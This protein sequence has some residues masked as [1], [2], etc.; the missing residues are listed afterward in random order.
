MIRLVP[1]LLVVILACESGGD[2][3]ASRAAD[4]ASLKGFVM[5]LNAA[6]RDA[7]A[8]HAVNLDS[9]FSVSFD[10]DAYYV[11]PWG[12]SEPVD[13]TRERL[14]RTLPHIRDYEATLENLN[15]RSFGDAAYAWF[16]LR[17]QYTVNGNPLDEYLP[18]TYVLRR[19]DDGWRV[20][21]L[22][23]STEMQNLQQYVELQKRAD[24]GKQTQ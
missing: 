24:A 1:L 17:Q 20:V 18:T 11:T 8:G 7:Y 14:K 12:T 19:A 9:L 21:H 3:T 6:L 16:I 22:Q 13:S 5:N 23:R 10:Q 2:R 15:V 4:E